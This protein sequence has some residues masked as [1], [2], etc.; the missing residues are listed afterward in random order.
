MNEDEGDELF[1]ISR[2]PI[3]AEISSWF[4]HF[5]VR[6]PRSIRLQIH[7]LPIE[8]H[9]VFT[10][11]TRAI[12]LNTP[13]W[14]DRTTYFF[15]RSAE[16]WFKF[17]ASTY[18]VGGRQHYKSRKH[19][20]IMFAM[21]KLTAKYG[22]QAHSTTLWACRNRPSAANVQ[23]TSVWFSRSV[24]KT[25]SKV[26]W[27]LFHLKQN[28]WSL[29]MLWHTGFEKDELMNRQLSKYKRTLKTP[30]Q[31]LNNHARFDY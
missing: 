29:A 25:A 24:S 1:F 23:S 12:E 5:Y 28:C 9:D 15:G 16:S 4:Q 30:S 2:P 31:I 27:W 20:I 13:Y 18:F 19:R 10:S 7:T 11:D 22:L 26:C 6:I 21:N 14:N 8:L 3:I 17:I